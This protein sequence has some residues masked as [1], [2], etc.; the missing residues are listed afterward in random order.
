MSEIKPD[1]VVEDEAID[2]FLDENLD[3]E[4]Q[5]YLMNA[6]DSDPQLEAIFEAV[7]LRAIEF[8]G[9]GEVDGKGT[10]TSD[11]IPARLSD[12]EFVFTAKAVEAIGVEN[13]ERMM[14]RAEERYDAA[15]IDI[16]H[17]MG[18]EGS[19]DKITVKESG[20]DALKRID[21]EIDRIETK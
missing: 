8:S 1:H 17:E 18:I 6:I 2:Y 4:S 3:V 21:S 5:Q 13:L 9:A 14:A 10:G 15:G 11:E 7:M 19:E 16:E 12:G 20:A